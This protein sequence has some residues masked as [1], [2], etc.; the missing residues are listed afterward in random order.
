MNPNVA[1]IVN[2]LL[3]R[4]HSLQAEVLREAFFDPQGLDARYVA[5]SLESLERDLRCLQTY[6]SSVP[7][8]PV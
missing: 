7:P 2:S 5:M 3:V 6:L 1:V 8:A 4:I